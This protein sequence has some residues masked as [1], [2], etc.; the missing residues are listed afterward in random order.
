MSDYKDYH[1]KAGK[2]QLR[3]KDTG[4][5]IVEDNIKVFRVKTPDGKY[6]IAL[7]KDRAYDHAVR[8][9][10]NEDTFTEGFTQ[11]TCNLT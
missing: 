6:S 11:N 10:Q 2:V 3:G 9:L 4:Y 8:L 5:K 1:Y 7:N